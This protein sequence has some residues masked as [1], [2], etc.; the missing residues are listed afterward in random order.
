ME[1]G[2]GGFYLFSIANLF[3]AGRDLAQDVS[4]CSEGAKDVPGG[5]GWGLRGVSHPFG[6]A[7]VG[8]GGGV[9]KGMLPC[10][11]LPKREP[12][13]GLRP[14]FVVAEIWADR[15]RG[16]GARVAI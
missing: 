8:G 6:P 2:G 11:L 13:H 4:A 10:L 15:G 14:R 12:A 1:T 9:A 16:G 5:R 7:S 3:G